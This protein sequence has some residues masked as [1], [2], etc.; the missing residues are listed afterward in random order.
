MSITPLHNFNDESVDR[1][2]F[3]LSEGHDPNARDRFG[4]TPLHKASSPEI[5]KILISYGA[6]PSLK[7]DSGETPL[8]VNI[9]RTNFGSDEIREKK[10]RIVTILSNPHASIIGVIEDAHDEIIELKQTIKQLNDEL[11][12]V[13]KENAN[14]TQELNS[15]NTTSSKKTKQIQK[16]ENVW[17]CEN[18]FKKSSQSVQERLDSCEPDSENLEVDG[19]KRFG[20]RIDC[21][22]KCHK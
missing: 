21:M 10:R 18:P 11:E 13:R 15:C 7:N 12:I 2:I 1:F 8:D 3:L 4:N 22:S 20:N 9:E 5:V 16:K 14:I 6:D 17:V 19:K